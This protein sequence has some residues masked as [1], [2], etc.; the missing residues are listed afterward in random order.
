MAFLSFAFRITLKDVYY[1]LQYDIGFRGNVICIHVWKEK[2]K[3]QLH[4]C[5][6]LFWIV[7]YLRVLPSQAFPVCKSKDFGVNC[8]IFS[9]W[10]IWWFTVAQMVKNP[11]AMWETWVGKIPGEGNGYPLQFSGLENSKD[12]VVHGVAKSQTRLSDFDF[13]SYHMVFFWGEAIIPIIIFL[14]F[15]F[16][17]EYSQL[18][19]CDS[20][21]WTAKGFSHTYT[22]I[23]SGETVET[24]SDFNF[25][26]S[27]ITADGDCSHEIKRRLLLFFFFFYAYSLEE[28]LWPT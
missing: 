14:T 10:V 20:F 9:P 19:S 26:G 23:H 24:V 16:P 28:K 13:Q 6:W 3:T 7:N 11:P 5:C 2:K 27:K 4:G 1:W 22:C 15:S 18:T 17:L 25:G 12:P 21:R 8:L